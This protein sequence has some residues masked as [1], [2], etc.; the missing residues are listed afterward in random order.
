MSALPAI[1]R[2][3]FAV[4]TALLIG[5]DP[6]VEGLLRRVLDPRSWA[7]QQVADNAAALL[8]TQKKKL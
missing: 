7:I 5:Q 2:H 6:E 1:N 4:K 3:P 8:S